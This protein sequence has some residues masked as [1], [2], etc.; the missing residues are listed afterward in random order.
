MSSFPPP[1]EPYNPP[2]PPRRR[3]RDRALSSS[4]PASYPEPPGYP[5]PD[6]FSDPPAPPP[7]A[8]LSGIARSR[9]L[10]PWWIIL[11][12][13]ALGLVVLVP[14]A[15]GVYVGQQERADNLHRL[16]ETHFQQA[17][18]Y[19]SENY[20]ELAIAELEIAVKFDPNYQEA[21][22]R[23]QTLKSKNSPNGAATPNSATIAD[24][25]WGR[26]Q[27]AFQQQQWSDAIDYLEEIRRADET[28][29]AAEV[30]DLLTQA[31]MN[32][33][34]QSL[35]MGQIDQAKARFDALVTF[36][37]T[38]AQAKLLS[39]RSA[40]YLDGVDTLDTNPQGAAVSLQQLYQQD[41]NFYDVKKQL[42]NAF[43]L[44]GD[45][46]NKQG[47]YCIAAREY[48]QAVKLGADSSVSARLTQANASCRQAILATATPSPTVVAGGTVPPGATGTPA[49]TGQAGAFSVKAYLDSVTGT[50]GISGSVRDAQGNPIPGGRVRIYNDYDYRPDPLPIDSTGH[51]VIVL[52]DR[53]SVFHLV[54]L[55]SNGQP[56]SGVYDFNFPGG[57]SGCRWFI[58]WTKNS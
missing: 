14:V 7:P 10:L 27:G 24:Q 53:G 51:Y 45:A 4:A 25:L 52:G 57:K 20:T 56:I 36:D 31:Y 26:A 2:P 37:P 48:D 5:E 23:L 9:N 6:A 3:G 54:L 44:Y 42:L 8:L 46:A 58:D 50:C 16:A 28:Y 18:A 38:N 35:Q 40:L 49:T 15:L 43:T 11:S 33:G 22:S 47:A 1:P 12:I 13:A 29:R 19:E 21:G 32:G 39:A 30:K 34:K 55:G 17:L 41:P